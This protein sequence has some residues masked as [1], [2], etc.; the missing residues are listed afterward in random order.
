MPA[1]QVV[2]AREQAPHHVFCLT[3]CI[4]PIGT[5]PLLARVSQASSAQRITTLLQL[6]ARSS[7]GL[8]GLVGETGI[9]ALDLG[10]CPVEEHAAPANLTHAVRLAYNL[11]GG[12]I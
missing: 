12:N 1:K 9:Q 2:V 8:S 11:A 5:R 6:A 10:A 4:T 7:C 3:R